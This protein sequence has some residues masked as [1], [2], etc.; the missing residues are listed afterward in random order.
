MQQVIILGAGKSKQFVENPTNIKVNLQETVLDWQLSAFES[1][2]SEFTFVGGYQFDK[3]AHKYPNL[4]TVFNAQWDKTA[5][6]VSLKNS[7]FSEAFPAF[8]IYGDILFRSQLIQQLLQ[9]AEQDNDI[10][11]AIDEDTSLLETKENSEAFINKQSN[12]KR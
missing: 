9:T 3:I 4:H 12:K 11:V 2:V 10:V 1:E 5:C 6:D 8:V 7:G